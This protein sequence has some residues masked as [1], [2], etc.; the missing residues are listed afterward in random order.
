M[1]GKV[2]DY[3]IFVTV[4]VE[5]LRHPRAFFTSYFH[6]EGP[7]NHSEP[8]LERAGATRLKPFKF[9]GLGIGLIAVFQPLHHFLLKMGGFPERMLELASRNWQEIATDYRAATGHYVEVIDLTRL[10]GIPWLD[11]PIEDVARVA[12]YAVF[13][14]LFWVFSRGRLPVK[15]MM[16]YF[17]YI[18]G[19]CWALETVCTLI[20]DG[21]Y[22]LGSG[23]ST[24]DG[25][26]LSSLIG[27]I[28]GL[29][30]LFYLFVVPAVI[31]P[32]ILNLRRRLIVTTT[33]LS[34]VS[35]GLGGL[36]LAQMMMQSGVVIVGFGL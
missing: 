27:T 25:F 13:A 16:G 8:A 21:A 6:R 10:T 26:F 9:L 31:L 17:A 5:V 20:G 18:I 33:I 35:W 36:V 19:A 15:K 24:S 4:A 23:G 22:V 29:A 2:R 32:S 30:H 1:I 7:K 28:G 11:A 12:T 3:R 14:V 34:V